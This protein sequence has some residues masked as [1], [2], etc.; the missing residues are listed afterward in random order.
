MSKILFLDESGDHN[1]SKIDPQ[2]PLFVLGGVIVDRA[3]AEGEM[4]QRMNDFKQHVF[5]RT[6]IVLHTAEIT[7]NQNAFAPLQN[8]DFRAFFYQELNHLMRSLQYTVIACAIHKDK[9]LSQYGVAA[10]DPYL[11]SLDIIVE[12]FGFEI[13]TAAKGVIVAEQRDDTLNQQ[14]E[15]AWLNLKVQGTRF[16]SASEVRRR[17]TGLSLRGKQDNIAGLQLADLVVSPIGRHVLGKPEKEDFQIIRQKL[18]KNSR[19][20]YDGY[21]LIVLPK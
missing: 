2:Y 9:H 21:G 13:G 11:M 3:Y 17:F 4:T 12:R 10:L 19:G 7:R 15:L 16:L 14:L 1:L 8:K 6:D 5:G 18:R 20:V